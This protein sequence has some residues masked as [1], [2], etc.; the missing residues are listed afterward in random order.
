M[1]VELCQKKI[2]HAK[3]HDHNIQIL[4]LIFVVTE[5][6]A[7]GSVVKLCEL[8]VERFGNRGDLG[9][10]EGAWVEWRC[11]VEGETF[12]AGARAMVLERG[13][14]GGGTAGWG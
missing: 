3:L 12:D 6:G 4:L 14:L 8:C 13:Y 7:S 1:S 5:S 9:E 11:D 2:H 10:G